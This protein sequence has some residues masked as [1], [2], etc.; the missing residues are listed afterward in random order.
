[1]ND[2]LARQQQDQHFFDDSWMQEQAGLQT[3]PID[4]GF[5][6][7]ANAALSQSAGLPDRDDAVTARTPSVMPWERK[8]SSIP[9]RYE[10]TDLPVGPELPASSKE[11]VR[12]IVVRQDGTPVTGGKP[13]QERLIQ[14]PPDYYART[15]GYGGSDRWRPIWNTLMRIPVFVAGLVLVGGLVLLMV[16]LWLV[17]LFG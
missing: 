3:T 15:S 14:Q 6:A 17:K 2:D 4:P 8:G 10:Q 7:S 1:M 9:N 16:V 5:V 12:V 11:Q 13:A